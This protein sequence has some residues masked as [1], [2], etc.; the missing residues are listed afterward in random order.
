MM[1]RGRIGYEQKKIVKRDLMLVS[2]L[3]NFPSERATKSTKETKQNEPHVYFVCI[4]QEFKYI[5]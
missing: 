2:Q 5:F 1:E 3:D 4:L